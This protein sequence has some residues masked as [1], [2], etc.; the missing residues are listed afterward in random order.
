[1]ALFGRDNDFSNDVNI[2]LVNSFFY[3]SSISYEISI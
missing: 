2:L 3:L 1:M